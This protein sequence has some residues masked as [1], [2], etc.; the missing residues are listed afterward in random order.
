MGG[1]GA[2]GGGGGVAN[3]GSY[4]VNGQTIVKGSLA[5]KLYQNAR[6]NGSA[7][8]GF[9][10]AGGGGGGGSKGSASAGTGGFT[11]GGGKGGSASGG[12]SS[13][14]VNKQKFPA[15]YKP[16]FDTS[17]V[18]VK[19]GYTYVPKVDQSSL[20]ATLPD[21]LFGDRNAAVGS[22][23][24][25]QVF[26]NSMFKDWPTY[27]AMHTNQDKEAWDSKEAWKHTYEYTAGTFE[28]NRNSAPD[29]GSPIGTPSKDNKYTLGLDEA[30]RDSAVKPFEEHVVLASS[31]DIYFFAGA[32][33][34]EIPDVNNPGQ[35]KQF[36]PSK[37]MDAEDMLNDLDKLVGQEIIYTNFMSTA[38][39]V[40]QTFNEFSNN[41]RVL[42][43]MKPGQKGVYVSGNPTN[44]KANPTLKHNAI[45]AFNTSEKEFVLPRNQIYKIVSVD[46]H[47]QNIGR[48]ELDVVIEIV[49]QPNV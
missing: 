6:K 30:F 12:G 32:K 24:N 44:V 49:D 47:T 17:K 15:G 34:I 20:A 21:A 41:I 22:A 16:S 1:R 10:V 4:T 7:A 18:P 29:A 14:T 36:Q 39:P 27:G 11:G 33:G 28:Y 23:D 40:D 35:T 2:K 42:V 3:S 19:P 5:D 48:Y 25:P 37:S 45:S 26:D 43:K 13:T 8:G 31:Q 46:P 9:S 38:I